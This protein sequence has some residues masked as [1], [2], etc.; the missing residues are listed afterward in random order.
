MEVGEDDEYATHAHILAFVLLTIY[1][2]SNGRLQ[3][4]L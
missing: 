2:R 1:T 4:N 3:R